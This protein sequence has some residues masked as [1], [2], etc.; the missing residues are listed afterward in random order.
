MDR[1]E[2][3]IVNE[4]NDVGPSQ[5]NSTS[6][7]SIRH[8]LLVVIAS[9]GTGHLH[10]LKRI[11]S[12]YK[13]MDFE[14]D[15]VVVSE[16]DKDLGEGV[17][18]IVGL[19]TRNPWSLP[20]AHKQ[21]FADRADRYDLF[22]YTEDDIEVS[23]AN[24]RSFLTVQ[25]KLAS[26]EIAGFMRYELFSSGEK[27]MPDVHGAFHW[28]LDS[29]SQR[30]DEVVAEFTNEHAA[31]YVLTQAQLQ[32]ALASSG[33]LRGP[34]RARYN[35]PET[36]ATDIYTSCG[37][38]KVIAISR[39]EEFLV[40]HLP[41]KYVGEVGLPLKTF[42][43][44]TD[45][46]TKILNHNHPSSTLCKVETDVLQRTWSKSFYEMPSQQLLGMVP[47]TASEV[48]SIGCGWGATEACLVDKGMQVEAL[49]L[50][51]VIGAVAEQ[52][53]IGVLNAPLETALEQLEGRRFDAILLSDLIH[54]QPKPTWLMAQ[55]AHLLK[56]G[57]ALVMS[58]PNFEYLPIQLR[59]LLGDD[60]HRKL[61]D[62]S[63]G[64][65]QPLSVSQLGRCLLQ[66]DL[67]F[68]RLLWKE[69]Y[70]DASSGVPDDSLT[71]PIGVVDRA[72]KSF[73]RSGLGLD[74]AVQL[75][76]DRKGNGHP[77]RYSRLGRWTAHRWIGRAVRRG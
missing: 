5:V 64:G 42:I 40:H 34:Y 45:A 24:I 54:L 58:G 53:K 9:Y 17:E 49:P 1:S 30:G 28:K 21:V 61:Q 43:A 26:D 29:V 66:N 39:F 6:Q 25:P 62:F 10:L 71:G 3:S 74:P 51:S 13:A 48:L 37:F 32:R 73:R 19:P 47:D 56:P 75:A 69:G 20:F 77:P 38:R 52:Q 15:V 63:A 8:R 31:F 2:C 18:V 46:L 27:S 11:I 50:D 55:C 12:R 44:Q 7:D 57:G 72:W 65:I 16:S 67:F 68:D 23:E 35:W 70:T 33:F 76:A 59:T 41:N 4:V 60:E 36:A 22:A 14:V